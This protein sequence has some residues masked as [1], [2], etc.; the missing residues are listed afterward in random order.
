MNTKS[1]YV[2]IIGR[3][4]AGK[5][6]LLNKILGTKLSIVTRKPQTTR[7]RVVGIY[8]D[9]TTQIV[10]TDNPGILDPK[11]EMQHMMMTYVT[12]SLEEADVIVILTD[13]KNH[14]EPDLSLS[15]AMIEY[16]RTTEKPIILILNKI[17][18]LKDVK[19]VLPLISEYA[20]M[21]YF[22]DIIPLSALKSNDF[23]DLITTITKYLPEN[24]FYYDPEQLSTQNDRFFVSEIIREQIFTQFSEEIPYSAEVVISE[25]KER[26]L[27][28]WYISADIIVERKSQ[29]SMI[30]GAQGSKIKSIGESARIAIEDYLEMEV[31]LKLFVKVKEKWR[32]DRSQLLDM[33]Y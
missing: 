12:D 26:E 5:S 9:E 2:A 22:K 23:L 19:T 3:P 8:S 32:R 31:F 14:P 16:I 17:D 1:G 4:N 18:L 7:K 30:I 10:F 25:Y 27:G 21:G 33:G 29:K 20:Q 6:T 11:Y 15:P 28:K 24:E 13:S